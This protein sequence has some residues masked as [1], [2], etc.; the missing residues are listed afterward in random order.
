M[1]QQTPVVRVLPRW[2]EWIRRWPC[3]CSLA[4]A[5][6][7]DVLTAWDRLGYPRRALR[8]HECAQ[9]ICNDYAGIV[10]SS[11]DDLRSLPG[12]GDYTA[13]AVAAFAFR[14]RS[15]VIDTNVRRVLVRS[16]LGTPLPAPSLT[17]KERRIAAVNVP[18]DAE[19]AASW[20]AAVMELGA[21]VCTARS[22][23]CELCP[24]SSYCSYVAAGR[25]DPAPDQRGRRQPFEGT[26]RQMRGKIMA[27]LRTSQAVERQLIDRLD[28]T[29][30]TRVQRC[31]GS[32]IE[33][34]LAQRHDDDRFSL[35]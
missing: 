27:L 24:I 10:P 5:P 34:G 16:I 31:L 32:L 11:E 2:L 1:L 20:N 18:D 35:P 33:D 21:L 29:D 3:P 14:Q 28:P 23:R 22:A 8:L 13:A 25:P 12:I 7:A 19:T 15:V 6:L 17:A 30:P 9:R 26:D 4:S